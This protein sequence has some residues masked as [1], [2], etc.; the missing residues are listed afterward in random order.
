MAILACLWT[1]LLSVITVTG[2]ETVVGSGREL[3]QALQDSNVERISVN[4]P[5]RLENEDFPAQIIKLNRNLTIFS[6]DEG[7]HQVI[8]FNAKS[9]ANKLSI[10]PGY[11]LSLVHLTIKDSRYGPGAD[12]DVLASSPGGILYLHDLAKDQ[13]SCPPLNKPQILAYLRDPTV[14]G[15][16]V[17]TFPGPIAWDGVGYNYSIH[18]VDFS[19]R[20]SV[21]ENAAD[22]GYV[23]HKR[24]SWKLCERDSAASSVPSSWKGLS[25]LSVGSRCS[26]SLPS[27]LKGTLT[28][29][30]AAELQLGS[31]IGAGS[32]GR[33][34]LGCVEG[35]EVAIKV[36]HH[37]SRSA[38]QVASEVELMMKF[39]HPHLIK[40]YHY[41][42]WGSAGVSVRLTR[43]HTPDHS[44]FS[45]R[46][47]TSVLSSSS[48]GHTHSSGPTSNAASGPQHMLETWIICELAN[49]GNLQDAVLHH[50]EGAF[51]YQNMPHMGMV[52][53]VLLGVARGMQWLHEHN[54]L[55]GDLK[56]ANVML[57]IVPS[58]SSSSS[59]GQQGDDCKPPADG[60]AAGA[61]ELLPKVADFGLSRM[62]CEGATHL[63]THTVGTITHQPPELMRSG[64]LSK[65][66]D[67]YSFGVM[68][69]EVVMAAHPWKGMMM[70]EIMSKVMVE[71]QRLQFGPMVPKAYAAIAQ[72]CWQEDPAARPTFE[73]L[74][75]LLQQLQQQEH[76]LQDEVAAVYEG[77]VA[78][79]QSGGSS[80]GAAGAAEQQL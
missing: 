69:W 80:D 67:V 47:L 32:F 22:R 24:N 78:G 57:S 48:G 52:L 45:S 20:M 34:F 6:P 61:H 27:I 42:T 36:V 5:I 35:R 44:A 16:N 43:E 63:S 75:V 3:V 59:S 38:P 28:A 77:V 50:N 74:V 25:L 15:N 37:D 14:P 30:Q 46:A 76:A 41:V 66:A 1:L 56:A 53:Q 71:G 2:I 60:D 21:G 68:M 33:V 62:M 58:S 49:A 51:F 23:V 73:Q 31:L 11:N 72:Q 79:W 26:L 65:P 29:Q 54:V 8:D 10:G 17:I 55:H 64:R 12:V 39:D 7:P 9:V 13:S 19:T 4:R 70:G 18:Y 40:A